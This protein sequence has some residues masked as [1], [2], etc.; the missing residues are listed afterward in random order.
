MAASGRYRGLTHFFVVTKSECREPRASRPLWHEDAEGQVVKSLEGLGESF[1]VPCQPAKRATKQSCVLPTSGERR[2]L[3][4]RRPQ[5]V[6]KMLGLAHHHEYRRVFSG[7]LSCLPA[8]R[9]R[10]G[11]RRTVFTFWVQPPGTR[12][13][14]SAITGRSGTAAGPGRPVAF[15]RIS[16]IRQMVRPRGPRMVDEIKPE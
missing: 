1:V 5:I 16:E 15:S 10:T 11:P 8:V 13:I 9:S 7:W 6:Y 2:A 4:L 14:C 12:S 3:P